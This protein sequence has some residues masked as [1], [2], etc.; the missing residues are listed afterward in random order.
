MYTPVAQRQSKKRTG[1][2]PVAERGAIEDY[3]GTLGEL[4]LRSPF[5]QRT[6]TASI[7]TERDPL[8]RFVLETAGQVAVRTPLTLAL[9]GEQYLRDKGVL[10]RGKVSPIQQSEFGRLGE[11]LLGTE[12][13]SELFS[14]PIR[15]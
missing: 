14:G 5:T 4:N 12:K 6:S 15:P 7:S 9:T 10:K 3:R 8:N 11:T 1:Y 13:E 2:I